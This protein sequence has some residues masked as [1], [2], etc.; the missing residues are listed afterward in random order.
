MSWS[1]I[2]FG[3]SGTLR[4]PQC[5]PNDELKQEATGVLYSDSFALFA[6]VSSG[7]RPAGT[8]GHTEVLVGSVAYWSS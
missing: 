2:R 1:L 4:R 3:D 7:S 8:A 5:W 6:F